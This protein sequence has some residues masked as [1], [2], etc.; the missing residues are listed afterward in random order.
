MLPCYHI[1]RQWT[2]GVSIRNINPI[3]ITDINIAFAEFYIPSIT[4]K[5]IKKEKG[6]FY[7]RPRIVLYLQ[8]MMRL[9]NNLNYIQY[10][11]GNLPSI[12]HYI[13][14]AKEFPNNIRLRIRLCINEFRLNKEIAQK[15]VNEQCRQAKH[16]KTN[17]NCFLY[18]NNYYENAMTTYKNI[19]LEFREV[20]VFFAMH[21][22]NFRSHIAESH[23]DTELDNFRIALFE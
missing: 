7:T 21:R 23:F 6:I 22:K 4:C 9:V 19:W 15:Y 14:K 20:V 3:Q 17:E 13:E 1:K 2:L 18:L 12:I 10:A 8:E 5:T 16:F 11:L